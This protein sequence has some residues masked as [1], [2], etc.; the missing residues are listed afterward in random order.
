MIQRA[1]DLV[2]EIAANELLRLVKLDRDWVEYVHLH[3]AHYKAGAKYPTWLREKCAHGQDLFAM[4]A[5]SLWL[6][7]GPKTFRVSASQCEAMEQVSVDLMPTEFESP[8]PALLVEFPE[9]RY[10]PFESCLVHNSGP[11]ITCTLNTPGCEDD[12]ITTISKRLE[13]GPIEASLQRFDED[14]MKNAKVNTASVALRVA[15]NSCLALVNYGCHKELLLKKQAEN[16]RKLA[17][18]QS[19]RGKKARERLRVAVSVVSFN[20]DIRLHETRVRDGESEATGREVKSH[21]RRGHWRMQHYGSGNS[22]VKR[23]L[24]KPVLVRADKFVGDLA[25]TSATYKG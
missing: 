2:P 18:E 25:D 9:G 4:W 17:G 11:I 10:A 23:I 16:D 3:D 13:Q 8:Y 22:Q 5:L 1:H 19:E 14:L 20:Q 15:V 12:I 6:A 7:D 21:W 24:I